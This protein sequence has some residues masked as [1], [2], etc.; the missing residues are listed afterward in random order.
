[1]S[2]GGWD[3]HGQNFLQCVGNCQWKTRQQNRAMVTLLD[4]FAA[5]STGA[6]ASLVYFAVPRGA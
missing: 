3:T 2:I 1:V 4:G 5:E 6:A